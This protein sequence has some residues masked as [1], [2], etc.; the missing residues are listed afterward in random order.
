VQLCERLI[1]EGADLDL[2][3]KDCLGCIPVLYALH[4]GRPAIA[5]RLIKGGASISG[6]TCEYWKTQ[7]FTALHY[8]ARG[9]YTELLQLLLARSTKSDVFHLQSAVHPIHLA[10]ASGNT[11]C[12]E[13]LLDHCRRPDGLKASPTTNLT[14]LDTSKDTEKENVST[15]AQDVAT[16]QKTSNPFKSQQI[17]SSATDNPSI[18]TELQ[19]D[20]RKLHWQWHL[21]STVTTKNIRSGTALHLASLLGNEVA[22]KTLLGRGALVDSTDESHRTPLHLAAAN[23]HVRLVQLLL[24]HSA[25]PNARDDDWKTPGLH[26]ASCGRMEILQI[27]ISHGADLDVRDYL[28]QGALHLAALSGRADIFSYL[29]FNGHDL[30]FKNRNGV[31]PLLDALSSE[32]DPLTS[33]VL[34]YA[35]I[36]EGCV[37]RNFTILHILDRF[38]K[39]RLLKRVLKRIPKD[40]LTT[41]INYRTSTCDSPLYTAASVGSCDA[42]RMLLDAGAQLDLEGG[43][44]GSPL[45]GAC[46]LGR[47]PAVKMLVRLGARLAYFREDRIVLT[48]FEAAKHHPAIVRWLLVGRLMEHP[49]L[50]CNEAPKSLD[51]AGLWKEKRRGHNQMGEEAE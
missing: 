14:S 1:E 19:I 12:L 21:S 48:A 6:A 44:F 42:M 13:L 39:E 30:A 9:G 46:A 3:M 15:P 36:S 29:T 50:L 40:D 2:G 37:S 34:N 49:K 51:E 7:G 5:E 23:G 11:R 31:S 24:T 10:V 17:D 41:L 28:G 38:N 22:A 45:M 47:L 35:P 16:Y 27:L 8:A 32:S 20:R 18:L 4:H 26:A 33:F 25:S 43:D